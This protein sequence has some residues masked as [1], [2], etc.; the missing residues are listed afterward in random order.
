MQ[1]NALHFANQY[2]FLYF[3]KAVNVFLGLLSDPINNVDFAC[4]EK[5][6][7]SE[8]AFLLVKFNS[9]VSASM[10]LLHHSSFFLCLYTEMI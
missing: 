9:Q 2:S 1:S 6:F 5:R 10:I 4:P 7:N 3:K 8:L